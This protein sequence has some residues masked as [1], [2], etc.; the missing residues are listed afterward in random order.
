M[1][2][3]EKSL[4]K[5]IAKTLIKLGFNVCHLGYNFLKIAIAKVVKEPSLIYCI[6]NG[7]YN[8]VANYFGVKSGMLVE[9][10]IRHAISSAFNRTDFN[11][12]NEEL[13]TNFT[14][15]YDRPSNS[16]FIALVAENIRIEL[17]K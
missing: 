1:D 9:R 15:K 16:L 13:H 6:T 4:D 12:F 8:S 14:S 11:V 3:D 2:K 17:I 5:L 7:L 10:C